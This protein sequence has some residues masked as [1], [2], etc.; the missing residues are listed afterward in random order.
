VNV[1]FI[2]RSVGQNM[3][4][5][6][7]L[8]YK[9]HDIQLSSINANKCRFTDSE[10]FIE[11]SPFPIKEGKTNPEDLAEFFENA[12]SAGYESDL[13]EFDC[14]ILKSCYSANSLK[15]DKSMESQIEA[16]RK[17]KHYVQNHPEQNFIICTT[18]PRTQICTTSKSVKRAKAVRQWIFDHFQTR[19]NSEV[20]DVFGI[21]AN[22]RGVLDKKYRRFAFYDQHPNRE[23]SHA[24]ATE[25]EAL[26]K[27]KKLNSLQLATA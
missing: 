15:T 5:D 9:L 20:L 16:Y 4:E 13:N 10:G 14:I 3:L 25:L 19:P 27:T 11:D 8:R 22:Q 21:L 18:P 26:L 2:H 23:G 12:E 1:L 24:I 7:K 17:I 6:S